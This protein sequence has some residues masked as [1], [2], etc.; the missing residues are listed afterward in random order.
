[1]EKMTFGDIPFFKEKI[2]KSKTF[3]EKEDLKKMMEDPN[4]DP[5][6]KKSY[7]SE[8]FVAKEELVLNRYTEEFEE[9]SDDNEFEK[10]EEKTIDSFSN[11]E[12]F[13]E[14]IKNGSEVEETE[15]KE[16][17]KAKEKVSIKKEK[18]IIDI[19]PEYSLSE[20][21]ALKKFTK[22]FID[23]KINKEE[24]SEKQINEAMDEFKQNFPENFAEMINRRVISG[25]FKWKKE[26][27]NNKEI[28]VN[29]YPSIKDPKIKYISFLNKEENINPQEL[30]RIFVEKS[31]N[32]DGSTIKDKNGTTLIFCSKPIK[33]AK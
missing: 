21:E 3:Q 16:D 5:I 6:N 7:S 26:K 32:K 31:V 13:Y 8:K 30:K 11:E 20:I 23:N 15:E 18:R 33:R 10:I 17:I 24:Y 22:D 14:Y 25:D 12:S 4:Y 27:F 2:E 28:L 9:L 1:M 29:Y 19:K